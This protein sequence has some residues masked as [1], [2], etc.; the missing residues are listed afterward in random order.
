[1]EIKSSIAQVGCSADVLFDFVSNLENLEALLPGDQVESFRLKGDVCEFKVTGGFD[2]V[3]KKTHEKKPNLIEFRSQ[4]GT[5]IRFGLDV[6]MKSEGT[7]TSVQVIC[8][9][10]LNPFL[11]MMAE[12]PLQK[13]FEGM[14]REISIKFPLSE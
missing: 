12:K 3:I 9:A 8:D 10:D 11:R 6:H 14:V 7:E 2:V 4:K 5:P 13:M 1:M